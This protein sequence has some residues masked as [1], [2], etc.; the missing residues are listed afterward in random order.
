MRF[1]HQYSA[2]YDVVLVHGIPFS[3]AVW[4]TRAAKHCGTP[5]VLLP[6][7]HLDDRYYHWR[8]FYDAFRAADLVL[9]SSDLAKKWLFDPLG[10]RAISIPGG[11]VHMDEF[12]D[13]DSKRRRF[14]EVYRKTRPFVL[15]LGRKTAAK[16][17]R[18]VIEAAMLLNAT[19]VMI[20]VV[21]IGPDEDNVPVAEPFAT[22]LGPQPREIVLGALAS[23]LCVASMSESESFGIVLVEAWMCR[24][25]VLANRNCLAFS[26]LIEEGK[27]G[28]LCRDIEELAAGIRL[29]AERP[30]LA[31][32]YGDA[33]YQKAT[34]KYTWTHLVDEILPEL[35]TLK[36]V[37]NAPSA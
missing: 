19:G 3:T 24:R 4:A 8:C 1:L 2:D 15:V 37:T 9:A 33:G 18:K 26:G 11:A 28:L 31:S 7:F 27:D 22:Y 25:P 34:A 29:V 32:N 30:E 36:R 14:R 17:Y 5:V 23:C 13:L 20:D 10:A 12:S 16:H 6:H 35:L 21:L